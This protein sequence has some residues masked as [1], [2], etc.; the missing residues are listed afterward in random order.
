[1]GLISSLKKAFSKPYKTVSV[2]EA[3][4]LLASGAALIDVRTA[5]EWR[6]GCAPQ[7]RHVPL[8]RLQSS[9]A[10]IQKS[11][12]VIAVCASGVRSASAAKLLAGQGYEAYSL[13]G[14][15]GAWRQAGEPI[16]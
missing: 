2:A 12:P 9:T 6:S 7:A 4:E 16:R 14:G 5:Q 10:G 3:K 13:S 1:M 8:D 15:M 11:R